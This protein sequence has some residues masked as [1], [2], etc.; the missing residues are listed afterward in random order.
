M[1]TNIHTTEMVLQRIIIKSN[2]SHPCYLVAT[3][4][5]L[6][7]IWAKIISVI[8]FSNYNKQT[9]LIITHLLYYIKRIMIWF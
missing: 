9:I 1:L 6:N 4:K 2:F 3:V 7:W 8:Q 5:I